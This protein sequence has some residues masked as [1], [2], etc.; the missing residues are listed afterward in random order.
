MSPPYARAHGGCSGGAAPEQ[1]LGLPS[2]WD[3]IHH[4]PHL[5]THPT[6]TLRYNWGRQC[7]NVRVADR[8]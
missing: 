4:R 7:G 5:G 6:P 8:Y 2:A 1:C 3:T